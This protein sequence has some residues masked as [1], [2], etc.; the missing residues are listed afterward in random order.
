M[1]AVVGALVGALVGPLVGHIRGSHSWGRGSLS[2]ALR[3]AHTCQKIMEM[4]GGDQFRDSLSFFSLVFLKTP[5][6]TPQKHQGY[7]QLTN[8]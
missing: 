3:V 5:R 7:S 6:K 8:P 2:P 1:R 4:L